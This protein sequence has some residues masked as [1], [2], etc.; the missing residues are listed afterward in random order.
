MRSIWN[1]MKTY[2]PWIWGINVKIQR[3]R[4]HQEFKFV[5]VS[6]RQL[7]GVLMDPILVSSVYQ[8]KWREQNF[9]SHRPN[10]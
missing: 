10:S 7:D 4:I 9:P 8:Q 3:Q 6:V 1:M 5:E 2:R